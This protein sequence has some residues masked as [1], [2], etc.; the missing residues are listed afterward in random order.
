M[1]VLH[2]C[3]LHKKTTADPYE[4]RRKD[5]M[6]AGKYNQVY[7]PWPNGQWFA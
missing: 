6:I 7:R 3:C 5:I 4:I 1:I 2:N